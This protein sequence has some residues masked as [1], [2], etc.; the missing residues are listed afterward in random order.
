MRISRRLPDQIYESLPY[1]YMAVGI[2]VIFS[3]GSWLGMVSGLMLMLAGII[4]WRTRRIYR[5]A[6][7]HPLVMMSR[8]DALRGNDAG[9]MRLVWSPEYECGHPMIDAQH[10]RLF[11]LGNN[12]LNEILEERSKLD[13]E[14]LLDELVSDLAKHFVTE[15]ALLIQA[16]D[17]LTPEHQEFHRRLLQRC[18]EMT[19]R[20]H[21]DEVKAVDLFR[22]IALDI[23][24]EHI[25][26]EDLRSVANLI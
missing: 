11:E 14:L 22:F 18:K 13:V 10:R 26:T 17:S 2:V 24:S 20:Y 19:E 23:V 7:R 21:R 15:E 5:A 12:L 16:R 9:L 8:K 1:V 6:R 25:L 3:L 4:I